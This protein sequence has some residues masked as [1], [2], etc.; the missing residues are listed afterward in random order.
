MFGMKLK[1][2]EIC[3]DEFKPDSPRQKY[4]KKTHYM[5]CPICGKPVPIDPIVGKPSG[6]SQECTNKIRENTNME[7]YGV[8][9]AGAAPQFIEKRENTC[10]ERHGVRH[11]FD[12]PDFQ[13]KADA[14]NMER[15]NTLEPNTNP[16]VQAKFVETCT[17]QFG[18]SSP[19]GS[20]AIRDKG[21]Q[22]MQELYGVDYF[23]LSDKCRDALKFH[24]ISKLN[25]YIYDMLTKRYSDIQLEYPI[26]RN[27]YDLFIPEL[28]LLLEINPTAS[29]NSEYDMF[30]PELPGSSPD[31]HIAK[32]HVAE[33]AGY[34]CIALFDW[35]SLADLLDSAESRNYIS[36]EPVQHWSSPNPD[37]NYCHSLVPVS[38]LVSVYDDGI[39]LGVITDRKTLAE[40]QYDLYHRT[41]PT[42]LY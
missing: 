4:C 13:A 21:K 31:R 1:K 36:H 7:L 37:A 41:T 34:I 18:A 32:K 38:G 9:N 14:T 2:C 28:N 19:L 40:I 26:G 24:T 12:H 8:A 42:Y 25:L 16:D 3:G 20:P 23:V 17:A 15:Y 5:P 11:Y 29:H 35:M 33:A 10:F 22:T 39:T 30:H 6:C 27:R